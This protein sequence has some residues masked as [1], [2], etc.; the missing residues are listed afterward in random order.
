MSQIVVRSYN[1]LP[2]LFALQMLWATAFS[3]ERQSVHTFRF[4]SISASGDATIESII[5]S[6]S[7]AARRGAGFVA[8]PEWHMGRPETLDGPTVERIVDLARE[9]G[10]WI[11][12]P[13]EE[14]ADSG[15]YFKTTV[16]V[17]HRGD[18]IFRYRA[19]LPE[20]HAAERGSPYEVLES[21]P[22]AGQRIGVMA[23]GDIQTVVPRLAARGA[24]T[25][26]VT[27]GWDTDSGGG[28]AQL[29]RSL[30]RSYG[31][32]LVVSSRN[33][34]ISGV[35]QVNGTYVPASKGIAVAS[36]ENPAA[37]IR[38]SL[39]LPPVPV[40]ST[41]ATTPTLIELGRQLFF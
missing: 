23:G 39:G 35:Y 11:A 36:I 18:L 31:V 8:V 26:L 13:L 37:A 20:D 32:N 5:S 27:A 24:V 4:A 6:V 14:A 3:G 30:S 33:A 29:C 7:E 19:I 40:P 22:T 2:C 10:I 9:L 21:I 1:C 12:L 15:G 25:V 38:P 41:Y 34:A 16:M 28:W 17:N